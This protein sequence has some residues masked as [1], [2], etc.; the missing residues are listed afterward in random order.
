MVSPLIPSFNPIRITIRTLGTSFRLESP[1]RQRRTALLRLQKFPPL[2]IDTLAI[3]SP[4][5]VFLKISP[6]HR[7]SQTLTAISKMR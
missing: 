2:L 4:L 3:V 6:S 1:L 7:K 5:K